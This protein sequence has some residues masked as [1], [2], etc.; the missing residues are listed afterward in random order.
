MSKEYH[1]IHTN[2][3]ES[4]RKEMI[5]QSETDEEALEISKRGYREEQIQSGYFEIRRSI[6]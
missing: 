6:K 5:I 2:P 4:V 1:I 3:K